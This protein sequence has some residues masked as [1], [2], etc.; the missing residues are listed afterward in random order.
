[1]KKTVCDLSLDLSEGELRNIL[2][3]RAEAQLGCDTVPAKPVADAISAVVA[4]V[5]CINDL[6]GLLLRNQ[7]NEAF[8]P[9]MHCVRM[10]LSDVAHRAAELE[11][12]LVQSGSVRDMSINPIGMNAYSPFSYEDLR[13]TV[14]EIEQGL[15]AASPKR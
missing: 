8:E 1:M 12:G 9:A 7:E 13:K 10:A 15:Q 2:H 11:T 14:T 6:I 3:N 5:G 4:D